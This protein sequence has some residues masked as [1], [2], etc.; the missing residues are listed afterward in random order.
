MRLNQIRIFKYILIFVISFS[1]FNCNNLKQT[2]IE[3]FEGEW[4]L[5]GRSMFEGIVI[6]IEKKGNN[7]LVGVITKLNSNKY[8]NMFAEVGDVWV[9]N[10]KRSSNFEFTLTEKRIGASLFGIYDLG[11]SDKYKITF[12]DKNKVELK[13]GIFYKRIL[14]QE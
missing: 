4:E 2:P 10:I 1:V 5:V 6:K 11:T 7:K 12:T 13:P 3:N 9:K 8:V 14:K